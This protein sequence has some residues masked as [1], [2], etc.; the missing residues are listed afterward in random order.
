VSECITVIKDI[1]TI[2]VS[3]VGGGVAVY[4]LFTWKLQLKGNI[5]YELSKNILK[6][7]Y[8]ARDAVEYVRSPFIFASESV[9]AIKKL[10]QNPTEEL[11]KFPRED[12]GIG[13]VYQL[14]WEK[15]QEVA[16]ELQA[17]FYEA[18]AIW[19]SEAK[20]LINKYFLKTNELKWALQEHLRH[21]VQMKYGPG[22]PQSR[23]DHIEKVEKIIFSM[24]AEDPY[25]KEIDLIITEFETFLKKYML[26]HNHK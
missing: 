7:L 6:N 1:V 13:Y 16:I 23:I 22:A 8:R 21:L 25:K 12:T 3:L 19:G 18:E 2:L 14:R 20:E 10:S 17:F 15:Y 24:G 5:E 11:A 4:G 9:A 26:V